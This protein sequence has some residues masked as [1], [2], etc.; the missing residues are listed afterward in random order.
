MTAELRER[1]LAE[2]SPAQRDVVDQLRRG[3]VK[4][5]A[6]AGSGKTKTMATLYALAVL[7]GTKPSQILAVTFTE[8]GAA[9]LRERVAA[10]M[11]GSEGR[12]DPLEKAWIGTFHRLMRRLLAERWYDSQVPPDLE[13]LDEV[14]AQLLLQE[15]AAEVGA[16]VATGGRRAVPPGG[17]AADLLAVVR[18][19]P[20]AVARLRS[21][22]LE[23]GECR[24]LSSAA[25]RS[26][27]EAG[28]PAE[29]LSWH[30]FG[31]EVTIA[32][33]EAYEE[34]LRR[35]SATDFDGLL[36]SALRALRSSPSL[37]GWTRAAFRLLIVDEYQDTSPIQ[38]RLLA[39][40]CGPHR[41][42]MFVV[43]DP[44]QSIF[45]FRDAQP[46]V[47]AQNE[48]RVFTLPRNHRSL[49]PI[50]SAADHVIQGDPRFAED[51]GLEVDRASPLGHP[52]LLGLASSAVEEAKGIAE[53]IWRLSRQGITHLD[54]TRQQVGFGEM[55]VLAP[56]LRRVGPPLEEELRRRGIPFQTASGGLMERPEV[57]DAVALLRAAVN[58]DDG[59][60]WIRVLQSPFVRVSDRDLALLLGAPRSSD[61]SVPHR[62][63]RSQSEPSTDLP[64]A[65]QARVAVVAALREECRQRARTR[66]A[67]EMLSLLLERAGV[68]RYHDA[69]S[70]AG[71]PEGARA[72]A[73]LQELN[74]IAL[75]AEAG[76]RFVPVR[77]LL[78]RLA[79]LETGRGRQEPAP[80][81]TGSQVTLSTI[82][83]AKGLEWSVVVLADCRPLRP[84]GLPRVLWDRQA[85][86]LIVTGLGGKPT[87]ARRRWDLTSDAAVERE[88]RTRLIYVA[89][90][91]AR[92]LLAVTTSRSGVAHPGPTLS[93]QREQLWQGAKHDGEYAR[94]LLALAGGKP[95]VAE[96]PG[97]P[98][99]VS[100]PWGDLDIPTPAEGPITGPD[101]GRLAE[102]WRQ[103]AS[104]PMAGR[105]PGERPPA[106]LSYSALA[107]LDSCPRQ[108][109]FEHVAGFRPPD[110]HAGAGEGARGSLGQGRQLALEMGSAVHAVLERLH[111]AH[112]ER[113]PLPVEL[114]R[115]L[116]GI[117]VELHLGDL[118][119]MLGRYAELEVASLPTLG[120]E[121]PFR[122]RSWA[123]QGIP[124]LVGSIDRVAILGDGGLL[125]LDYKTD[126]EVAREVTTQHKRQLALYAL[127]L[128]QG[129]LDPPRP[130]RA[131]L[132]L[133]RTGE[134]R[135]VDTSGVAKASALAWAT[136]LAKAAA[137]PDR[138]SALGRDGLPCG[139][140]PFS[141]FCP[142]RNGE[143]QPVL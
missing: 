112:P 64:T 97:F 133:L 47:M 125:A 106:Q 84:R 18:G 114:E 72:L 34:R 98:D 126:T 119:A 11:A 56:T 130:V 68:R 111:R 86:A 75:A 32:V 58:P 35:G 108:F 136:S 89:M 109:W 74:R 60:A 131:A 142:E 9:E 36:R 13:L 25:Y 139:T 99:R 4:V 14:G 42:R 88:E 53:F 90:T 37:A 102:R 7:D 71:D 16:R 40:L 94:L 127:A 59:R 120:V 20:E 93:E 79:L 81:G 46:G 66:G 48:G 128:E 141:W 69:R 8:R 52:V 129:L 19:A 122:W 91:R 61:E 143:Q 67:S 62:L 123:G 110:E 124:P 45:A 100:L 38:D 113:A 33:W 87:E 137:D 43:G 55:A 116:R 96:L 30:N 73:S 101:L 80:A 78:D 31:L 49:E 5:V 105:E 29:E 76:G 21:T 3:P 28:D 132:V 17:R 70:R 85:E 44:R 26:F 83:R 63:E 135:D 115:E 92:D 118:R 82:H 1:L 24:R 10:T 51:A 104:L 121:V 50:L 57:K 12:D 39:E 138:L 27:E 6:A 22:S 117:P 41:E 23:P 15:A 140:C 65:T 77:E 103:V 134:V 95:W 54:G 107:T 2:L